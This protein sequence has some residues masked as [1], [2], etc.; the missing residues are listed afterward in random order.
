MAVGPSLAD[1]D[2]FIVRRIQIGL[3][4]LDPLAAFL[5]FQP[6]QVGESDQIFALDLHRY[7]LAQEGGDL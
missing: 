4:D 7:R 1:P 6:C 5:L 2:L 3:N